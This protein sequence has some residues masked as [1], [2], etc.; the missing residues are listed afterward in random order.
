MVQQIVATMQGKGYSVTPKPR[1]ILLVREAGDKIYIVVIMEYSDYEVPIE[2][3]KSIKRLAHNLSVTSSKAVD[4]LCICMVEDSVL[5]DAQKSYADEF[6]QLWYVAKDT[7]R[8]FVYENQPTDFD[9]IFEDLEYACQHVPSKIKQIPWVNVCIVLLN[10][11][12]FLYMQLFL[13]PLAWSEAIENFALD[14]RA[15]GDD[16]QWYR[17]FTCMYLHGDM[18]HIYSN[19]LL[20]F[21]LG[22]QMEQRLGAGKYAILYMGCGLFASVCSM[23]Y[24]CKIA[25]DV[26]CLGASG[27]IYGVLGALAGYLMMNKGRYRDLSPRHF[28]IF[29]ALSFVQGMLSPA[30]DYVAHICGFL[31][32]FLFTLV[33]KTNASC[34][35]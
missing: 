2:N 35:K 32:G 16:G 34:C 3:I 21:F 31:A 19:M 12:I 14:W 4:Y 23:T 28:M 20:L 6:D 22:N 15:V 5:S 11:L 10:V 13:N 30:V 1:D 17:L 25:S 18:S 27:A 24:H 26:L 9:G 8:V 29:I 7:G 33:E